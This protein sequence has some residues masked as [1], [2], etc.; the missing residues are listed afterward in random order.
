MCNLG[1]FI[2]LYVNARARVCVYAHKSGPPQKRQYLFPF[3]LFV[4]KFFRTLY[5]LI[6]TLLDWF[7]SQFWQGFMQ[8]TQKR[9]QRKRLTCAR[10][11]RTR[12]KKFFHFFWKLSILRW[13]SVFNPC[14]NVSV[15]RESPSDKRKQWTLTSEH[16]HGPTIDRRNT[17]WHE[18]VKVDNRHG[19]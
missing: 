5:L 12:R 6:L 17:R 19:R 8:D 2:C 9:T 10:C 15:E 7:Q 4:Q 1:Y 13:I 3:L 16:L 14:Y 11:T 18:R